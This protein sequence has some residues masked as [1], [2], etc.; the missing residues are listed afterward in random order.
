MIKIL[1]AIL[2]IALL[3]H[4]GVAQSPLRIFMDSSYVE[5]DS[6]KAAFYKIIDRDQLDSDKG[7]VRTYTILGR[8]ER[9]VQYS[10][11]KA[12]TKHGMYRSYNDSGILVTQ[13]NYDHDSLEGPFYHFYDSGNRHVVGKYASNELHDSL[14]TWYENGAVRRKDVY[15]N[16]QLLVGKCYTETGADTTYFPFEVVAAFPGGHQ[17]MSRWIGRQIRYPEDAIENN[18]SGKVYVRFIIEKD[19]TITNIYIER[20]VSPSMD[21]EVIRVVNEMPKWEPGWFDGRLVSSAFRLPVNFQ[22]DDDNYLIL[23]TVRILNNYYWKKGNTLI[24]PEYGLEILGKKHFGKMKYT[25][26]T[27]SNS[28]EK[29]KKL[30]LTAEELEQ[31]H[32]LK[33]LTKRSCK[34]W[35]HYDALKNILQEKSKL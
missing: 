35:Y 16:G 1:T 18:I 2:F 19:G 4:N 30:R 14:Y 28:W 21:Q 10:S 3:N 15:N 29:P 26:Y 31:L 9:E 27:R 8:L 34:Y 23:D 32:A 24:D 33:F 12:K 22:L 5:C 11:I 17:A 13:W 20:G 25:I 7:I 6:A